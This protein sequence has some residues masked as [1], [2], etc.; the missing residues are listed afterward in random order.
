MT[1][2]LV[3]LNGIEEDYFNQPIEAGQTSF[4]CVFFWPT[5]F[6]ELYDDTEAKLIMSIKDTPCVMNRTSI[7]WDVYSYMTYQQL[8][9]Q[10]ELQQWNDHLWPINWLKGNLQ[11]EAEMWY[12]HVYKPAKE[13]LEEYALHLFWNVLIT[14]DDAQFAARL[15]PKGVIPVNNAFIQVQTDLDYIGR[16]NLSAVQLLVVFR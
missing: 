5:L 9:L 1:G 10:I 14:Q 8:A 11:Y 2:Y 15:M 4:P 7:N 16:N 3:Q 12:T 6:Q 13:K